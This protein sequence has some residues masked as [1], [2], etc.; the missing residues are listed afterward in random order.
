MEKATFKNYKISAKYKGDKLWPSGGR[1]ENWNNHLVTVTNTDTGKRTQFDFWTSI[2]QPHM[3][4]ESDILLAFECFLNDAIDYI[5]AEDEWEFYEEFGY[6][7]S[8]KAHEI[9]LACK[10]EAEKAIRLVGNVDSLYEL[11]N[12]LREKEEEIA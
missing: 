7:P 1:Y 9:W 8:K 10:R 3:E 5:Q 4:T 11:S 2:M 6:E 12:A